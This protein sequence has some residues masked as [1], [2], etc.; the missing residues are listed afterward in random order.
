MERC[1]K[2]ITLHTPPNNDGLSE[3]S[4]LYIKKET[5]A[6]PNN[7]VQGKSHFITHVASDCEIYELAAH[8]LGPANKSTAKLA[9]PKPDLA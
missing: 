7:V 5:L 9:H 4:K 8:L 3:K 6:V 2:S 1:V